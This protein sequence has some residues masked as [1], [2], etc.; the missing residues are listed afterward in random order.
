MKRTWK[1]WLWLLPLAVA[2][3]SNPADEGRGDGNDV[4]EH[5]DADGIQLTQGTATLN[6][7]FQGLNTGEI[8]LVAGQTIAD[9]V[10]TFL[11]EERV[12]GQPEP[13][14]IEFAPECLVDFAL[15]FTIENETIIAALA[16]TDGSWEFSLQ[17]LQEGST[18]LR[19]AL[20]HG[21]HNDF[22]SLA[23]PVTVSPSNVDPPIEAEA[24]FVEDGPNPIATWNHDPDEG[25]NEVTGP[26]LVE[27]GQTRAGLR[28]VLEGEWDSGDGGNESGSRERLALPDGP[29]EFRWTVANE[30]VAMISAGSSILEFDL[31]GV[32]AGKTEVVFELLHQGTAILTT[33]A[34]PVVCVDPALAEIPVVSMTC[35]ASGLKSVIVDEGVVLPRLLPG[36]GATCDWWTPGAFEYDE[37]QESTLYSVREFRRAGVADSCATAS[38]SKF[39]HRLSFVFSDPEIARITNHP[40]HWDEIT[41]FHVNG[42]QAGS[43][44][45]KIYVTHKDTGALKWISPPLPVTVGTP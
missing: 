31:V 28:A 16:A 8:E 38:I 36:E 1:V 45:M 22:L 40:F 24:L 44:T 15:G 43:T 29:Y 32:A 34:I 35:V 5:V 41:I 17:G 3:C 20:M 26:M 39:T 12:N 42:L 37:G 23:I 25:P 27:L 30:G 6:E 14:A 13:A 18:T 10:V 21:D 19:V 9:I 4:C 11:E 7:Q 2:A 33:G